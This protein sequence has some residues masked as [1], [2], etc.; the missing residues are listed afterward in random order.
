[1]NGDRV[2]GGA[3]VAE[4]VVRARR[5]AGECCAEP[6]DECAAER[7]TRKGSLIAERNARQTRLIGTAHCVD[8]TAGG[9]HG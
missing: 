7:T 2:A 1:M 6:G 9:V 5:D 4:A 8:E 3:T